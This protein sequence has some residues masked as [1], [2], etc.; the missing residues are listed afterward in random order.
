MIATDAG[1]PSTF[2]PLIAE[3]NTS[4]VMI[5]Q[6][7]SGL[8][9]INPFGDKIVPGL[10]KSWDISEDNKTYTF[11][12]RKGLKWSDGARLTADDIA[13]TFQCIYDPR[14][15]NRN[16]LDLMVDGKPFGVKKIDDL[17]IQITTADI[18]APFLE[19]VGGVSLL[20][21][22]ILEKSYEDGSLQK[23]WT[24]ETA[25]KHPEQIVSCGMYV[26]HSYQPGERIIFRANPRYYMAD[27]AGQRL[28]YID[29]YI[30]KFV[31]DQ[32]A[33][34][35]S[36]A[37]GL[38][39]EDEIP[40]DQKGWVERSA[41][42]HNFTILDR[43]PSTTSNFIWFNQNPGHDKDGKPFVEPYKLK[44]FTN[45]KFRQ[46]I[47]YGI[48]REGI[49]KGVLFGRGA[50]LWG[51]E[52]PANTKWFNPNVKKYPYSPEKSLALLKEIGFKLGPDNIL[53][54]ADGHQVEFTLMTN[55]ENPIRRNM[56]TAFME[57]M[58]N[59]GI[60]VKLQ[61]QEFGTVVKKLSETFDY[62]SSM[63]GLTGGGDPVGGMSVYMSTGRLHQWYPEEKTPAT[64][65]EARMDE[66]ME[67]QLKTLDE[68]KRYEYYAEVQA[69]MAE[70][71]PYI[72]LITPKAYVGY[73]N[74]WLNVEIPPHGD[75]FW[76]CQAIWTLHP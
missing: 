52:S 25:Q 16:A 31:K 35:A 20:P 5:G 37:A 49:V 40:P 59:L 32:N 26:I 58:K 27:S 53:R 50:P 9:D 47:S 28:P 14:Y 71:V 33:S 45:Q 12:L 74:R 65:W 64:P 8:V 13:F 63:L 17:T 42:L 22:H 11:H 39:D 21:K 60:S 29:W 10:A 18:Y 67:K 68:K 72:Y 66:L 51:P 62:E 57:N 73:K 19:M 30:V 75:P 24:I 43:G 4:S 34:I 2:N 23:Q 38:T 55:E 61:F 3:D 7:E 70:E 1:E 69:I 44:W 41:Q 36:F 15:P 76:N 6:L 46:A 48:D 54:D 56:A